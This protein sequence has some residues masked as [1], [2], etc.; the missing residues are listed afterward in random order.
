MNSE[1]AKERATGRVVP[2][3]KRAFDILELFLAHDGPL[4]AS[5]IAK[6]TGLPR[7]SVHEL[8]H[9]LLR[10]SYLVAADEAN[11]RRFKL[12][13]A[14]LS[15]G[16][17]YQT[18]LDIAREGQIVAQR[19]SGIC[20]ETVHVATLEGDQVLY[21]AKV[22]STRSVRMVSRVGG[23]L[24]AHV[25]GVGKV[26]LAGLSDAE[27]ERV[28]PD[29]G[30]LIGLTPNSITDP[31][32]L[33]EEL[34]RVRAEGVAFEFRES[35]DH[36]GCVAAPVRDH[37]GKTVAGM[38]ISELMTSFDEEHMLEH[39]SLVKEGAAELSA[40]LGWAPADEA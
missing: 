12:G 17:R 30:P 37:S 18:D 16:Y 38:S 28:L 22:D 15:L 33:R 36:V 31:D 24:P 10:G 4:S 32:V 27:L 5:E 1:T 26:L 2:A 35:N 9:T 20:G 25:T 3:V 23:R 8:V 29:E 21:V 40:R 11:T 19:I 7:T 39:A 13:P 14:L 6:L 34:A